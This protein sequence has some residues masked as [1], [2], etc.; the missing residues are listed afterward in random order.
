MSEWK[1]KLG[2][3]VLWKVNVTHHGVGYVFKIEEKKGFD[4]LH[5]FFPRSGRKV[6][7]HYFQLQVI[8]ETR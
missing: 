1:V 2:D 5:V 4:N 3:L 8:S 7:T 6:I